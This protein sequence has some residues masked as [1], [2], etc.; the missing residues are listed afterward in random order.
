[1]FLVYTFKVMLVKK[2]GK[3]LK[4]T[5]KKVF[6][7]WTKAVWWNHIIIFPKFWSAKLKSKPFCCHLTRK[8]SNRKLFY[9]W[10]Q[11]F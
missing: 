4:L 5:P 9:S 7:F 8:S 1:M 11:F 6:F 3:C 2:N 10:G